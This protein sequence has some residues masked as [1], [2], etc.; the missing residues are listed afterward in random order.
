MQ[1]GTAGK[2]SAANFAQLKAQFLFDVQV[3]REME[4]VLEDLIVNW[5][6]TGI[7]LSNRK[8]LKGLKLLGSMIRDKS[9]QYLQLRLQQRMIF[10]TT[11]DLPR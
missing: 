1:A 10:A 4:E 11:A 3:I 2:I 9:Q 5:D 8:D 7:G 6:Q